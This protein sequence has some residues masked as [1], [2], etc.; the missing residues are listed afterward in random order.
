MKKILQIDGGGI[1]G[2]IPAVI[3]AAVEEETG[4]KI[5]EM[6]DLIT[7]T[8]TGS[9]IGGALAAGVEAEKIKQMYVSDGTKLFK[10]RIPFPW[11]LLRVKYARKPF[12]KMLEAIIGDVKMSQLNTRYMATAFNLCSRRTHFIKSWD[13]NDAQFTLSDVI[14]W[15]ALSAA[16]YFG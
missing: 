7:G 6:F 12:L 10:K 4:R 5:C 2:I 1:R 8:S 3:C 15:S 9:I 16:Y 11:N 13:E 14:S